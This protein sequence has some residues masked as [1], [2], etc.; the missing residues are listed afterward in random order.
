MNKDTQLFMENYPNFME[1]SIQTFNDQDK[2]D[3]KYSRI[4]KM[5]RENLERCEK[6]QTKYPYWIYFSVNPMEEGK[7]DAASVKMI[8]TWITDIDDWDK[9]AQLKLIQ[10]APLKPTFVVESVHWFHLYYLADNPLDKDQ[11]TEGNLGLKDYYNGDV[12]VCKDTARVLRIP[13][14]YHMKGKPEMVK[15]RMDL[16]SGWIY[17]FEDMLKNFPKKVEEQPKVEIKPI[18]KKWD[19]DDSYRYK[20]NNLDNKQMLLELSGTR[21]MNGQVISFKPC[22][23]GEQIWCDGKSTSCWIDRNGMIGSSDKWWPT[24]VQWLQRYRKGQSLDRREIAQRLKSNH[25]ELEDRKEK[26]QIKIDVD[27]PKSVINLELKAPEFTW[28]DEELD[29]HIGKL[30][31]GQLVIL[32]WETGAGKTTFAT[33]MARKNKDSYYF[34]LEDTMGN[35]AKR[36]AL[37]RA[38]ITKKE[39]NNGTWSEEKKAMYDVAYKRFM[40]RD[41]NYLDIGEKTEIE[42]II[43]AMKDLKEKWYGMFFIDNLWF[44]IWEWKTEMEQTADISAKLV[45]FCLKENVCV[46][47][48]H[49]FKKP[50]DGMK[51]RDISSLRWSWKLWDDAFFV[52]NYRRED[53]WTLLEVLKDRTRWDLEVYRL[54]YDRWDFYFVESMSDTITPKY[55]APF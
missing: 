45:S 55:E 6:L 53:E 1:S 5:S 27:T 44:V 48:L 2:T 42:V 8:Q 14:F 12:K 35:I 4:M 20:V 16:S 19:C 32:S 51:R 26:K 34:V 43:N 7:R 24:R 21:R 46:V 47:L 39:L 31:R 29:N 40:E 22:S 15:F 41:I 52:A 28:W 13:W 33:F 10:D 36:Y 37:K 9:A 18:E 38:G 54:G 17:T 49:H 30:S 3:R 23:T 25:P 50:S 11:Y